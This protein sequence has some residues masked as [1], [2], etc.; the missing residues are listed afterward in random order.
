MANGF[1]K[2]S[3]SPSFGLLLAFLLFIGC[4]NQNKEESNSG[5]EEKDPLKG[6][7]INQDLEAVKEDGKLKAITGYSSTSYFIYRGKP[8]GYEY[9]LL[10]RFADYLDLELEI[11]VAEDIQKMFEMLN[12][13]EGELIAYGLTVTQ[14][15]KKQVDFSAPLNKVRQKLVQKKPDKWQYMRRHELEK[16]LITDPSDLE[17]D[18]VYVRTNSSYA[19]RMQ[20]L[21]EEIGGGITVI[22]APEEQGTEAL[23]ERVAEGDVEYTVADGNIALVNKTHYPNL[24]VETPVSFPQKL[25]WALPK[26]SPKLLDTIDTWVQNIKQKA[27]YNVIYNKYFK[28]RKATSKRRGSAYFSLTGNNL[29]PFD[30]IMKKYGK[31]IN[32]DWRLIAALTYQESN[33]NPKAKSWAGAKGLMQVM[34]KTAKQYDIHNLYDPNLSVKAG[35]KQI[36]WLKNYWKGKIKD[37]TQRAK[38]IL[39]SYN[40]GQG[41]VADARRLAKKYEGNPDTWK[42]VGQYL[43]KKSERQYYTD[44]VVKYGYCRGE[45]PYHYVRE[46]M[47]RYEH[48]KRF[49]DQFEE[50]KNNQALSFLVN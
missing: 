13:G 1:Y 31:N 46:I 5:L 21:N 39:A 19:E 45:E 24:H 10:E 44:P 38:F 49:I 26:N 27:V 43:R 9:E 36:E 8:M 11:I 6:P 32:W 28:N 37:S 35:T 16:H 7:T 47:N 20:N 15:R 14:S 40:V 41:H 3:V 33:F 25:A 4:S 42:V 17:G 23:I 22:E 34:P 48:Y 30:Q 12:K 29:S 50:E 2:I 18:T